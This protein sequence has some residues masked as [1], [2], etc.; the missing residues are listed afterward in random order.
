[1]SHRYDDFGPEIDDE[2]GEED[3]GEP[4][5]LDEFFDLPIGRRLAAWNQLADYDNFD[6]ES[7]PEDTSG[8]VPE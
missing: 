1:M 4:L 5:A 6:E 2:D 8:G 7:G 3:E